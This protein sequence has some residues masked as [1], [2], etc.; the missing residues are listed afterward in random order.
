MKNLKIFFS[1]LLPLVILLPGCKSDSSGSAGGN[2]L[3]KKAGVNEVVVH[4]LGDP[5]KINPV[6]STSAGSTYIEANIFQSLTGRDPVSYEMKPILAKAVAKITELDD[7]PY[8]G[9]MSLQYEIRDEAVWDNGT[10][11]TGH[12]YAFTIKAI[13]NPKVKSPHL[14]PYMEFIKDVVVDAANP[15]KF[16]V[17]SGDRYFL[18]ADFAGYN[19][20]PEYNYDPNKLMRKFSFAQLNDPKAAEKL[21]SNADINNFANNFNSEKFA[22]EAGSI[23]GSGAYEFKEWKTGQYITLT[24]KD[25]WWGDGITDLG[26]DNNPDK[27]EYL[28]RADWTPV[29]SAMKSEEIDLARGIRAKDF[30]DLTKNESFTQLFDLQSPDHMAYDYI[31]INLKDPKFEDVN[32]RK[33]LAHMV[34]RALIRDV[35]MY[36]YGVET[37]SPIHPTKSYYN[38]NLK[39]Y[40]FDLDK[41][42]SLLAEAGWEDS[43]NDGILDK[44]INGKRVPFKTSI[45]FNQ[46]NTRRENTCLMFKEN[47]RKVGIEVDVLVKEWT[48]FIDETKA[49]KFDLYVGGWVGGTGLSDL[50][51]IWHSD[52]YNGGSNYVGF[53]TPESDALIEQ[54]RYN[55]DEASRDKQY[56]EIQ[57]IIHETVPYVFLNAQK[58]KLAFHKRFNNAKAYVARPGYD[59]KEWKINPGFGAGSAAENQ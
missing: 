38:K 2:V 21:G 57:K 36:G 45:K 20:F 1:L 9:G 8:K 17:Y 15:K 42:K 56:A 41:S 43:D 14:R 58:N 25:N 26:F 11:V 52:S 50:K 4:E 39:S 3:S 35:L 46:G 27:I 16:T 24:K 53:G 6:L 51:Q 31:G 7:G 13:K 32:T 18:A 47:A 30:V 33:A 49:H 55:N 44:V 22:R 19:V 48:V 40:E 10:P 37:N 23:S 29:I 5:D 34:D 12:D 59:E 28:I 54:I